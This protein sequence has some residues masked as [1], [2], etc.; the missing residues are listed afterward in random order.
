[1]H[2]S[3]IVQK[4]DINIFYKPNFSRNI[5]F[6]EYCHIQS[7]TESFVKKKET[8]E[9]L[10]SKMAEVKLKFLFKKKKA[11]WVSFHKKTP[12]P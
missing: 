9:N 4:A 12:N 1:M 5:H 11:K 2:N 3:K 7:K 6:L 8:H 10:R